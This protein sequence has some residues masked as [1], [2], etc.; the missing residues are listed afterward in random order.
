MNLK[1]IESYEM[2]FTWENGNNGHKQIVLTSEEIH[3]ATQGN[4]QHLRHRKIVDVHG[5]GTSQ[6]YDSFC[7]Y[8]I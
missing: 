6:C 2:P 8:R 7:E 3:I 4:Q 1:R 5:C